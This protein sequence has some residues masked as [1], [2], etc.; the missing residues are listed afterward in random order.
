MIEKQIDTKL[1][2]KISN[3]NNVCTNCKNKIPKKELYYFEVGIKDHLHTLI[4]RRFCS[5]C[6]SK[7]GEK[8]LL[9]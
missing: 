2:K 3:I 1:I 7:F 8:K 9:G 6:Y 5:K 4:S